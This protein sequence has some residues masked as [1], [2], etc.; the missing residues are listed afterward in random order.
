MFKT[1]NFLKQ[2]IKDFYKSKAKSMASLRTGPIQAKTTWTPK[3]F[4]AISLHT[5]VVISMSLT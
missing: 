5:V 2:Q 4:L 3:A 1:P